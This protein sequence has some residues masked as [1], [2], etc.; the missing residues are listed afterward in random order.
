MARVLVVD[1]APQSALCRSI[2]GDNPCSSRRIM[3]AIVRKLVVPPPTMH[4]D[5]MDD[6]AAPPTMHMDAMDDEAAP[7]ACKQRRW[8]VGIGAMPYRDVSPSGEEK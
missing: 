3:W 5:A 6:E 2:G 7:K 1:E 8:E 4:M